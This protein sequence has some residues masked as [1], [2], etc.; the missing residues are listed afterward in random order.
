M[1]NLDLPPIGFGTWK[2]KRKKCLKAVE[3]ALNIGYRLIDTAQLYFNEKWVGKAIANSEISA[4]E[5]IVAT[6]IW[7]TRMCPWRVKRSTKRSRKKLGVSSIDI[8]YVHW[9]A[10]MYKPKKTLAAMSKLMDEGIIENIAVANFTPDLIEEALTI[11]E[12]PIIANQ[13]EMHPWLQQKELRDYLQKKEIR[14]IAY[15]PLAH[16]NIFQIPELQQIANKHNTTVIAVALKWNMNENAIPI[17]KA[18]SFEHIKENYEAINLELDPED[19]EL[20][21]NITKE[22]RFINPPILS[23]DW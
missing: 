4:D 14:L 5:I 15:S 8:L 18:S 23:P 22:K 3:D 7:V 2:L 19:M 12:K 11:L 9:P 20:I 17:P 1:T 21:N 13:V 16:G 6:K 10:L